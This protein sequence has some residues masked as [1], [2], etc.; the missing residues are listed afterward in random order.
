SLGFSDDDQEAGAAN[1]V[2][3]VMGRQQ[4]VSGFVNSAEANDAFAAGDL[5]VPAFA[6]DNQTVGKK[7]TGT[8]GIRSFVGLAM[9]LD[10]DNGN[11]P[12]I[13]PGPIGWL[14]ARAAHVLDAIAGAEYQ[15]ADG[16]AAATTAER[17][18]PRKKVKGLV[19][20]IEFVGAAVTADN[21]NNATVTISKRD[22]AGGGATVL[23]T[24][25]TDPDDEGAITAFVPK[26]FTLS[27]VAGALDL[28]ETDVLTVTVAKGGSG[29]TLTGAIRVIQKVG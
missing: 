19:T 23:G 3:S 13:Y 20:A 21:T 5:A 9:G 15:I 25:S 2:A 11:T 14:L 7:S 16:S 28:L 6:V 12:I 1:G 26:A 18:I 8:A 17:A 4:F 29:Q 24:L 22:G 27:A 10:E